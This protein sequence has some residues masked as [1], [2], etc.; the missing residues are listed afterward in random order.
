V[1]VTFKLGAVDAVDGAVPVVCAPKSGSRFRIGRT[2]VRCLAMDGS[3]NGQIAT[4]TVI[5]KA[6]H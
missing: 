5:V 3:G 4:F 2:R 1:R 6:R